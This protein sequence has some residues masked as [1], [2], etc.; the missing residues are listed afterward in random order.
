M[1]SCLSSAT[2]KRFSQHPARVRDPL[3]LPHML[4]DTINISSHNLQKIKPF[5]GYF[6]R[7][8]LLKRFG[9]LQILTCS[10]S[11]LCRD[12][13]TSAAQEKLRTEG[14]AC[15]NLSLPRHSSEN[16]VIKSAKCVGLGP[17][18]TNTFYERSTTSK[19]W[20][21]KRSVR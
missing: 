12:K 1:L 10:I 20:L 19:P 4:F 15:K 6:K 14:G 13:A 5:T 16:D 8:I 3:P 9:F 2:L 18:T 7:G 21:L 17:R 11:F